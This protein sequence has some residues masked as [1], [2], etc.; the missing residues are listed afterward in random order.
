MQSGRICDR[1]LPKRGGY[2]CCPYCTG[3]LI[4]DTPGTEARALPT[5]CRKCKREILIDIHRGQ[6]YISQSPDAT[7]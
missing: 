5:W 6:S 3:K 4:K 2:F 1:I 7:E